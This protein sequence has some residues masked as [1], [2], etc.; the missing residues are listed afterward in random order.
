MKDW[1]LIRAEEEVC[2]CPPLKRKTR[3]VL[4]LL[5]KNER[6]KAWA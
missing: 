2:A 1:P 4:D 5:L 3:R 6:G